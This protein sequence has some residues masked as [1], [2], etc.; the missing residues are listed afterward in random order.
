M[1][2][3]NQTCTEIVNADL[4]ER[5]CVVNQPD[6]KLIIVGSRNDTRAITLGRYETM[7]V[8]RDVLFELFTALRS[9]EDYEMPWS[10]IVNGEKHVRDARTK[11]RGGS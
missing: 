7:K 10:E 2:I 6:A 11:R 3:L 8:A 1:F 4:E 9:G 5:I